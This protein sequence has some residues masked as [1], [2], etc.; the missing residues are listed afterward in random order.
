MPSFYAQARKRKFAA[1][2]HAGR[3][4]SREYVIP[5]S[6]MSTGAQVESVSR[7]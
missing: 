3:A 7:S 6:I 1:V 2:Q 4:A 5:Y